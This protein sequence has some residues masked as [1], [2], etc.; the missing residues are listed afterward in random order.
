M[1]SDLELE[2][3][4]LEIEEFL[5]NY[6]GDETPIIES[7][8]GVVIGDDYPARWRNNPN[9]VDSWGYYTANCTS[10]VAHRLHNVNKF[11]MPRAIGD[12]AKWGNSARNLGYRVDNTPV[13][14]SVAYVDNGGYGHVAWVAGVSGSNVVI[15][16]YNWLRQDGTFDHQ[17][18]SRTVPKSNFTGYIHFKDLGDSITPIS[19]TNKPNNTNSVGNNSVSSLPSSGTYTFINRKGVKN[20]PKISSVDIA[21]YDAGETVN[22]DKTLKADNYQWISYVS[23]SGNRR[24]IAV[25]KLGNVG[26]QTNTTSTVTTNKPTIPDRGTYIFNNRASIR[27]EPKVSSPE[28]AYY[29]AGS[30][31]NYDSV[32]QS[33]GRYWISYISQSGVRRYISIS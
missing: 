32:L 33:E 4:L 16:E 8:S 21:Y 3:E 30:S 12:G 22:Y 10:F 23:F 9:Q 24:Y 5:T 6:E 17:Y 31:V 11:E 7:R 15:E 29:D 25:E 20:E 26:N 18:H 14:G 13:R 28:I 27:T 19:N 2:E 1:D